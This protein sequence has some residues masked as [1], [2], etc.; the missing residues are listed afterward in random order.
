MVTAFNFAVALACGVANVFTGS[1]IYV[2][3]KAFSLTTGRAGKAGMGAF[4]GLQLIFKV[5]HKIGFR[6]LAIERLL[7]VK[8]LFCINSNRGYKFTY[9]NSLPLT[10]LQADVHVLEL[11]FSS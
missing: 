11:A 7:A 8:K 4:V 10:A 2:T 1:G 5:C 6:V 3:L 9:N